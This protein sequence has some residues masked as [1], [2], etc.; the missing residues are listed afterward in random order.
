MGGRWAGFLERPE[1]CVGFLC[2]LAARVRS[3]AVSRRCAGTTTA[4]E[5]GTTNT[6]F[7]TPAVESSGPCPRTPPPLLPGAPTLGAGARGPVG[8]AARRRPTVSAAAVLSLITC[9]DC[10]READGRP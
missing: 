9:Q 6:N 3:H 7:R 1:W 2:F 5:P 8:E 4:R 10:Q